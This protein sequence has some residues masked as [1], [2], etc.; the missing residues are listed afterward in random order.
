MSALAA[1]SASALMP[2]TAA[3][4]SPAAITETRR[5]AGRGA[6]PDV[7]RV[8][9][10]ETPLLGAATDP[11]CRW[12][13]GMMAGHRRYDRVNDTA[14]TPRAS[15]AVPAA[16]SFEPIEAVLQDAVDAGRVP[17]LVAVL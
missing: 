5:R 4:P 17:G 7:E 16:A 9:H 14:S 3:T 8:R 13:I 2:H 15:R 1:P 6:G 10:M 11:S 12:A